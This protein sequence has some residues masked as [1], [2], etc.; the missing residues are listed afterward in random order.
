MKSHL[1]AQDV[2]AHFAEVEACGEAE[3]HCF[4]GPVSC[5]V[6]ARGCYCPWGTG[7]CW[8]MPVGRLQGMAADSALKY[9][10]ISS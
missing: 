9:L 4:V 6:S 10:V 1:V 7:S 2:T 8:Q 5:P 3:G